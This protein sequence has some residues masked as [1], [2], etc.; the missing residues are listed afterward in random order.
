M[1]RLPLFVLNIQ[2][3]S[4]CPSLQFDSSKCVAARPYRKHA[5]REPSKPSCPSF[6]HHLLNLRN[7]K[8]PYGRATHHLL[9]LS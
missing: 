6:L 4:N 3:R 7:A 5:V 9:P 8:Q 1:N 2:F